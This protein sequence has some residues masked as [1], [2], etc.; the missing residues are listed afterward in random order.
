M[1]DEETLEPAETAEEAEATPSEG[2][3]AA[4]EAA[5]ASAE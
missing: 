2:D 3:E 5:T 4:P 1:S